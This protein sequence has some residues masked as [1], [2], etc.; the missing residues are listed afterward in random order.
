MDAPTPYKSFL[1]RLVAVF[2]MALAMTM[3]ASMFAAHPALADDVFASDASVATA[4]ATAPDTDAAGST[5]QATAPSGAA[6]VAPS[7]EGNQAA[8]AP[9]T[10]VTGVSDDALPS[11][12]Q[13][14]LPSDTT[15]DAAG[16]TIG[17]ATETAPSVASPDVQL[18]EEG[19]T[20]DDVTI[21]GWFGGGFQWPSLHSHAQRCR[22]EL[23][24]P[25]DVYGGGRCNRVL[26]LR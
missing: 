13:A 18:Q 21:A 15:T 22:R 14:A 25:P 11:T 3:L 17:D 16:S 7:S 10:S 19:D 5:Q 24:G 12:D 1:C 8:T 20:D 4:P 6:I 9:A 2:A 26:D 23:L